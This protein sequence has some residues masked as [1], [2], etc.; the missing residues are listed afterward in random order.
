MANTTMQGKETKHSERV[1][2]MMDWAAMRIVRLGW[3]PVMDEET[4]AQAACRNRDKDSTIFFPQSK[5]VAASADA[6]KICRHCSI[7][8]TC[9]GFAIY[10]DIQFGVWGEATPNQR[11]R[12]RNKWKIDEVLAERAAR[13][14]KEETNGEP[15]EQLS[16]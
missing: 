6:R 12:V 11:T 9:V 3:V 8:D 2:A 7:A 13:K 1:R 5:S 14:G 10:H 15:P 4:E 16:V